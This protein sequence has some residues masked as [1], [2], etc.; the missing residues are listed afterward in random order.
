MKARYYFTLQDSLLDTNVP[1][2]SNGYRLIE[3]NLTEFPVRIF[4]ISVTSITPGYG[5]VIYEKETSS[6]PGTP[7][8]K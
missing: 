6:P 4:G 5:Y 3:K 2:Q 1:V 8:E 7:K